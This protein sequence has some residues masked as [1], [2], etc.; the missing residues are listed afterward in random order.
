[1]D[2]DKILPAD[3]V[4]AM[5][6]YPRRYGELFPA[7]DDD[8]KPDGVI[9]RRPEPTVWSMLEYLCHVTDAVEALG[10]SVRRMTIEDHPTIGFFDPD[11]R[12]DEQHYNQREREQALDEFNA[13]SEKAARIVADVDRNAWSRTA[14]FP[15]GERDALTMMRNMVHEG[16]HHLRDVEDVRKRVVGRPAD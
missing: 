13:A 2:Y 3:G 1:L 16:Y 9:R 14:T 6:S 8:E 15:W 7:R 4:A 12:A 5:R 11:A 10:D